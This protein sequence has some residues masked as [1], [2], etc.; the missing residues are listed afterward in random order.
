MLFNIDKE[1]IFYSHVEHKIEGTQFYMK[2]TI[3]KEDFIKEIKFLNS[4]YQ[5]FLLDD[6]V[7]YVLYKDENVHGVILIYKKTK[8]RNFLIRNYKFNNE[9]TDEIIFENLGFSRNSVNIY[10]KKLEK[11]S[12]TLS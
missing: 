2:E 8:N 11:E 1:D 10:N 9:Q 7:H 4:D 6:V 3:S 5:S 12:D